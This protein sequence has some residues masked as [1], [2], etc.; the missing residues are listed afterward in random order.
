MHG[1]GFGQHGPDSA[2]HHLRMLA[3]RLE[4]TEQQREQAREIVED[5]MEG[6]LGDATRALRAARHALGQVVHD[7]QAASQQ[8]SDA[9]R[10]LAE[11]E[12]RVALGR[13]EIAVAIDG[14]LTEEQRERFAALHEEMSELPRPPAP[15]HRRRAWH[16]APGQGD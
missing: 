7:P 14:L 12:E 16:A 4:F 9:A 2:M 15:P 5:A 10:R 3:H 13:H 1:H 11:I 8:I 6:P